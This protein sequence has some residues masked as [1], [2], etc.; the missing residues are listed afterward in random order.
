MTQWESLLKGIHLKSLK[1]RRTHFLLTQNV[2]FTSLFPSAVSPF[3]PFDSL[4]YLNT[5]L[6]CSLW[7]SLYS[8][9]LAIPLLLWLPPPTSTFLCLAALFRHRGPQRPTKEPSFLFL[10][11]WPKLF[12]TG[13]ALLPVMEVLLLGSESE[14]QQHLHTGCH[15]HTKGRDTQRHHVLLT[16]SFSTAA[17]SGCL[18]DVWPETDIKVAPWGIHAEHLYIQSTRVMR[19]YRDL[20][21][22]LWGEAFT[23]YS[24]LEWDSV[25][26]GPERTRRRLVRHSLRW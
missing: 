12:W 8:I 18:K 16:V 2:L 25:P 21:R 23:L 14:K 24:H 20:Q 1:I 17:G 6:I 9:P 5:I 4:Q 3:S 11:A 22:S 10:L 19:G 13:T 7:H 15:T 26:S